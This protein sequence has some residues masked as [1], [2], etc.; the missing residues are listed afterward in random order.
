MIIP[1]KELLLSYLCTYHNFYKLVFCVFVGLLLKAQHV[2]VGRNTNAK[3]FAV[4]GSD[5]E[6]R[7]LKL[8]KR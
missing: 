7:E 2:P 3:S 5:N 8:I 6:Y 1:L 4:V